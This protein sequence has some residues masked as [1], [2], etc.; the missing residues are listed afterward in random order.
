MKR[1]VSIRER[2][3]ITKATEVT[4]L[5]DSRTVE[6]ESTETPVDP[7]VDSQEN[8]KMQKSWV[9]VAEQ[10]KSLKKYEL[11]ISNAEGKQTV[12]VPSVIVKEA[13][14]LWEDFVIARFL[15]KAP[16]VAKVHMILNKIWMF[17]D[18]SMKI[19]VYGMDEVTMRIRVPSEAVRE[20]VVRRG[21]WNIA[22]I[23]M[24]ISKWS[25]VEDKS[26]GKLTPLWVHLKN[27]PMNM[28]S[29]G[30]L[31]FISSAAGVPDKLHPETIACTN[32]DVA[33]V[34]VKADLSKQLPKRINFNIEGEDVMIEFSYPWLPSKCSNC[35]K[36]GHTEIICTINKKEEGGKVQEA[37]EIMETETKESEKVTEKTSSKEGDHTNLEDEKV[38][39]ERG[40]MEAEII[41]GKENEGLM[42]TDEEIGEAQNEN[43]KQVVQDKASR[44]PWKS[45]KELKFGQVTIITPSRFAALSN[46]DKEE[47]KK[48]TEEEEGKELQKEVHEEI[49]AEENVNYVFEKLEGGRQF[50][51]RNS[52]T[53][54]RVLSETVHQKKESGIKTR[55]SRKQY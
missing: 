34:C 30:G 12:K 13:D 29:W 10:R 49:E 11:E 32:F 37:K 54:H 52:K 44:S 14:P 19:D 51:P 24:V 8:L 38:L 20:K 21:M 43:W 23:P 55:G 53:Y 39:N 33:K 1:T 46:L 6:M 22:G 45:A 9:A 3:A 16:H 50:L 42:N 31:S 41:V 5:Y 17:G 48:Q 18:K 15:E 2:K 26:E 47:G 7:P 28:Y 25:P 4:N 35:G 40:G 36:W 27:V